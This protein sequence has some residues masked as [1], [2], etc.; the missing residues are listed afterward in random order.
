MTSAALKDR[1][2]TLIELMIVVA[3]IG[4]LAAIAIPTYAQFISKTK[5]TEAKANLAAIKTAMVLFSAERACVPGV[6][7][8][9]PAVPSNA[10]V[11]WPGSGI[12]TAL[13]TA[14]CDGTFEDLGFRPSGLVRYQYGVTSCPT[15]QTVSLNVSPGC[16]SPVTLPPG[17]GAT[18]H[19]GF[20]GTAAGDLDADGVVA[21]FQ[22]GDTGTLV[23]CNP[24]RL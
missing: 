18:A 6:P 8:M 3:L 9:P 20:L 24:G 4:I 21:S 11:P 12:T 1:G 7:N 10:G 15:S 22:L 23:D 5:A 17:P 19:R 16:A 14:V 13:C 2:F